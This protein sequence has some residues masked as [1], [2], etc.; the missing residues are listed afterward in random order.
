[1]LRLFSQWPEFDQSH[2]GFAVF[3]FFAL[4]IVQV[5]EDA[6]QQN[7]IGPLLCYE[8]S[9][10]ILLRCQTLKSLRRAHGGFLVYTGEQS[11]PSVIIKFP[12]S[13]ISLNYPRSHSGWGSI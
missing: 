9:S 12:R 1:M 8:E 3:V 11:C 4:K 7:K 6:S 5:R 13:D 10:L 2:S